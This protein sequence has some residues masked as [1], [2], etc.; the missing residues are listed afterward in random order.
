MSGEGEQSVGMGGGKVGQRQKE[1]TS[2][3]T[4]ATKRCPR[5]STC[6]RTRSMMRLSSMLVFGSADGISLRQTGQLVPI[7]AIDD[8]RQSAQN[9]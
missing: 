7:A 6:G 3:V 9:E 8:D 1:S 2:K 5:T 4:G